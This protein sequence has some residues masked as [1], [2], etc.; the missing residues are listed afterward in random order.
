MNAIRVLKEWRF[1]RFNGALLLAL[2]LTCL[3]F[4]SSGQILDT[5]FRPNIGTPVAI[6][7]RPDGTMMLGG[8]RLLPDDR[9][10]QQVEFLVAPVAVIVEPDGGLIL[11]GEFNILDGSLLGRF[12]PDGSPGALDFQ[13]TQPVYSMVLQS[14]GPFLLSGYGTG[15]NP[16]IRLSADGSRDTNFNAFASYTVFNLTLQPDNKILVGGFFAQL[17][18]QLP[19]IIGRLNSDGSL[20]TNFTGGYIGYVNG[21]VQTMLLQPDGKILIGGNFTSVAG[22]SRKLV[23]RIHPDGTL[24]T[25]FNPGEVSGGGN[26]VASLALQANGKILVGG[27]FT[28]LSGHACTNAGRLNEDGSFDASFQGSRDYADS[29]TLQPG[30]QILVA[31]PYYFPD[32]QFISFARFLN[33]D[34]VTNLFSRFGSTLHWGRAGGV[35]EFWR[36]TFEGSTN[37]G[38]SWFYLGAGIHIS[39]GWQLT[40]V[41]LPATAH[42]RA[43]GFYTSGRFNGSS[44][45]AEK[46]IGPP[47]FDFQPESQTNV[48]GHSIKLRAIVSGAEPLAYYWQKDGTNLPA[49]VGISGV[50][51]ATLTLN[52]IFGGRDAGDYSLI[53]SNSF[54]SATS[55]VVR[56]TVIEPIILTQPIYS[57]WASIG[58]TV[59]KTITAGGTL[60]LHYQWRRDGANIPSGDATLTIQNA[61][62]SDA[63]I[64]DVIISNSFGSIT[65]DV[66]ALVITKYMPD[67]LRVS[68]ELSG[69]GN[70]FCLAVQSD[71]R[72]LIGGTFQTFGGH[73]CTNL[74]RINLDGSLDTTFRPN[75]DSRPYPGQG[76]VNTL[77]IQADGKILIGGYFDR[78]SEL[79]RTNIARLNPNGSLDATFNL[80][81]NANIND[82]IFAL[83]VQADGKIVAGGTFSKIAGQNRTNLARLNS[84]GTLDSTVSAA[85]NSAVYALAI[86]PDGKIIFGG[87][88]RQVS[89]LAHTNIA[90]LNANGTLDTSFN[91]NVFKFG[92][93]EVSVIAVQRDNKIL[94]GGGFQKLN[95]ESRDGLGRL[96]PDGSLD[97]AFQPAI[98]HDNAVYKMIVQA[99][100]KI[101]CIGDFGNALLR[102]ETNGTVDSLFRV[103]YGGYATA[104]SLAP[105][106]K[107]ILAG[108]FWEVNGQP[109]QGLCRL[110][111]DS[112]TQ[113]LVAG[114][115]TI[116]WSR[117]GSGPEVWRTTFEYSTNGASWLSLSNGMRIDRAWQVTHASLPANSVVRA[118]GFVHGGSSQWFVEDSVAVG[119]SLLPGGSANPLTFQVRV[120]PGQ[121]VV[122]ERSTNLVNW[123]P[124]HT[125][126]PAATNWVHFSD[127]NAPLFP[128]R[129]YRAH[130]P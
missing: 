58:A 99:D 48:F 22:Q 64:Y 28:T 11:G 113:S 49:S 36:T 119:L 96:N 59:Q 104:I 18:G 10:E 35:P 6:A 120:V 39:G 106:G 32:G 42:V 66:S 40:N 7:A 95:G 101:L 9:I 123:V 51:S 103:N 83:A 16:I 94:L 92:S 79:G 107:I 112:S 1:A 44:S 125:N 70:F 88:F 111:N 110:F 102:I 74:A 20:D 68:N 54:G 117:D 93:G 77:A 105:D 62:H 75:P 61:Q 33:T 89:G 69:S 29:V 129:F 86:S 73:P 115:S 30:G 63:G 53:V 130:S 13:W 46:I 8:M 57:E 124:I 91:A 116:T 26:N 78:V 34:P 47:R 90:R 24:D 50:S 108:S 56:L 118:R 98:G 41:S 126:P 127:P 100:G 82:V 122:I 55:R 21:S 76:A 5:N 121:T 84:N 12:N 23:A 38:L 67:S 97:T 19:Q 45:I 15:E 81:A 3:A 2:G 43:R 52:G 14:D 128:Q 25:S 109:R 71:G 80:N 37:G 17:N 72:M 114:P 60:P 31:S 27:D 65:S 4:S 87:G 85:P